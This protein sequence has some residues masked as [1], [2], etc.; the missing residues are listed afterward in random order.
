[1][2]KP[3]H[4]AEYVL[5]RAALTAILSLGYERSVRVARVIADLYYR[6]DRKHRERAHRNLRK[7]LPELSGEERERVARGAYRSFTRTFLETAWIPRLI[8]PGK[9]PRTVTVQIH[10]ESRRILDSGKGAIIVTGHFANWELSGQIFALLGYPVNSVART[11]DNP[12]LDAY[13]TKIRTMFGQGIV[14]KDGGV[15]GMARVLRDGK[16]I[17]L[18]VDQNTGRRGIV[19][20]FMGRPAST[21][22][23]PATMALRF[24][25][26]MLPGRGIRTGRGNEYLLKI[27]APLNLPRTGDREQ[28]VRALTE[29]MNRQIGD[30]IRERPDQWLWVHRRWKLRRERT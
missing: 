10:P 13:L 18:L 9:L 30:W 3:R 12:L 6:L 11:L 29:E 17:A 7:T 25:V 14:T 28:D 22:P 23:A 4:L 19:V 8:R 24:K 1:L 26:P 5:A 16:Q 21:T 20:D 27:D 2:Y 15:R